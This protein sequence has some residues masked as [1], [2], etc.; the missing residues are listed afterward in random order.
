MAMRDFLHISMTNSDGL[1]EVVLE[2]DLDAA[3]A[4]Q[5]ASLPLDTD[6]GEC[7]VVVDLDGLAVLDSTGLGSLVSLARRV[8]AAPGNRVV[9]VAGSEVI[10]RVL[11]ISG[12]DQ[13]LEVSTSR[14]EARRD[15]LG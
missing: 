5:V 9:F 7:R 2:G 11:M 12:V 3:S 15:A 14:D 1:R 8:D 10:R 6:G 4:G 13:V